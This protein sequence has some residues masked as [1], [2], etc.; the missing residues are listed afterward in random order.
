MTWARS[1]PGL[2]WLVDSACICVN[3]KQLSAGAQE[4]ESH[5]E[6]MCNSRLLRQGRG[7]WLISLLGPHKRCES[8]QVWEPKP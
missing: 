2:L 7:A 8:L 6:H 4:P 5:F 3:E 1:G